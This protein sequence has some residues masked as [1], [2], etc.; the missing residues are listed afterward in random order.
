MFCLALAGLPV[1]AQQRSAKRGICWDEKIFGMTDGI[2]EN[3]SAGV[4]WFHSWYVE[5]TSQ[6]AKI[7][8]GAGKIAFVPLAVNGQLSFDE[9]RLRNYLDTHKGEVKYLFAYNEPL[10]KWGFKDI[11]TPQEVAEFWPKVKKVAGDYGLKLVAP[12]LNSDCDEVAGFDGPFEWYDEFFRLCPDSGIDF[13]AF[14]C[15]SNYASSLRWIINKF[16]YEPDDTGITLMGDFYKAKCP[17]FVSFMEDYKSRNG[18]Y[19]KMFL[20]EFCAQDGYN[21]PGWDGTSE[22]FQIDQM[23]QKVL[24]LEK[25]E[26]VEGYAWYSG[27]A[28]CGVTDYPRSGFLKYAYADSEFSSLGKVYVNMSS[29]DT[30]KYYKPGE[31]VFAK[32]YVDAQVD[33]NSDVFAYHVEVRPNSDEG[34]SSPLQISMRDGS[35]AVYQVEVPVDGVYAVN[36]RVKT[37]RP[38][39]VLVGSGSGEVSTNYGW[40]EMT[41]EVPLRAGRQSLKI[42][43]KEVGEED[44]FAHYL[45]VSEFEVLPNSQSTSVTNVEVSGES[46]ASPVYDLQGRRACDSYRGIV[47]KDGNKFAR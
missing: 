45:T 12:A 10:P 30:S 14:H 24:A 21:W 23:T 33:I 41:V 27:N 11:M 2:V 37:D 29:F 6:T 13:L 34:S 20:T 16:F 40:T 18:H 26:H 9:T 4:S 22:D 47:V 15:Y 32:D 43:N 42:E 8:Q 44:W 3:L 5:S 28:P 7:G 39:T 31:R 35:W 17:H 38:C 19:P 46:D 25:S 36:L 1:F